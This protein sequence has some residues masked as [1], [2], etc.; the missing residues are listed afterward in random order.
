MPPE[1]KRT[2]HYLQ[3]VDAE[4]LAHIGDWAKHRGLNIT[5]TRLHHGEQLPE[6]DSLDWLVVMGGPMNIYEETEHPWLAD[7]K[8]FIRK[9]IEAGK[10]VVGVCLG[11][12]LIAHVLGA[13]ITR[14]SHTEI[15][16]FPVHQ[17]KAAKALPMFKDL[18]ET[19]T[20]FHWHGDRFDIPEGATRI[21]ESEACAEQSFLYT[22]R[23]LALQ[24]HLEETEESVQHL[25][26]NFEHEMTPGPYVQ[27]VQNV[28][29]GCASIP[30]MHEVLKNLLDRLP[31]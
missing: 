20:A 5:A 28:K 25:L 9:E 2:L 30:S 24:C 10:T 13:K 17:T 31:V 1:T 22:D 14:N 21:L 4:D 11:A 3:H 23:V 12:Q 29:E 16:W 26:D 18:P 19:F 27:S 15:G 7:E 6:L 8:E